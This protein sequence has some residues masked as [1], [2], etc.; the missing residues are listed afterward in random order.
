ME[1]LMGV[2]GLEMAGLRGGT[3]R[4]EP[5]ALGR[6]RTAVG[7][8]VIEPGAAGWDEAVHVWNAMVSRRPA[9]VLQPTTAGEVAA[10]VA[11]ARE[12][13]ILLSIKGGG[14]N[15][16]G[17][18]LADGG[19][20]LDM[21]RM[22]DVRVDLGSR[23][24]RV[25][26]GCRLRDVDSSTQQHGLATPLGFISKTGVAGLT[27]GGGFGYL[28]RRFGWAV[29]NL[30]EVEVVTADG[31]IRTANR[32]R[33]ADLFWAL[34]GGGGNFG[35]ATRFSF[36]LHEVG[37]MVTGGLML[38]DARRSDEVLGAYRVL[39]EAAPR[40][41]TAVAIIRL[42]PPAPF[43]PRPW[44]LAPVIAILVCH[45]GREP[46]ADLAPIRA[47]GG[48][49]AGGIQAM[50]YTALQSM[51]DDSEPDGLN[52]YWKTEYLPGLDAG[53]TKAFREAALEVASPHSFSVIFHIAGAL[54]E[55]AADDGAVGNRDA[56][57]ITGF[58]GA[59]PVGEPGTE[60][61]ANVRKGWGRIR[62]FSTGGNYVN[63]QLADDDDA[64]VAASYGG[65]YERLRRVK[66]TY[67]PENLFRV[68]RNI[69]PAS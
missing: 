68:N 22:N 56:Q 37:P 29:D 58:S 50:P 18:A 42:A 64:R 15:I 5:E 57:F 63:F 47:L 61:V 67:D 30:D 62:P 65:N 52:Q 55:R 1:A 49:V 39:T 54:N 60:I 11:F 31:Q 53:Y 10:A 48:P 17:T 36:R 13:G 35:A 59:W 51:L 8:H 43:V 14:H 20:T 44:H 40:E 24:A 12:R 66:Q 34:R 2:T 28:A 45:T 69:P 27:L 9:L 32:N 33:D 4:L 25:G 46:E 6:L 7:D 38:W 21:S 3:V 41:L 19:L 16:A 23:I 26:A